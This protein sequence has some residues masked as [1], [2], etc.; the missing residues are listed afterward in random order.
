MSLIV[1]SFLVFQFLTFNL[2]KAERLKGRVLNPVQNSQEFVF[3]SLFLTYTKLQIRVE[4][5]YPVDPL[6]GSSSLG[7]PTVH[8]LY[9]YLN[10]K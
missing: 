9:I 4:T 5:L 2:K 3:S 7:Q 10:H 6:T 8:C 1:N